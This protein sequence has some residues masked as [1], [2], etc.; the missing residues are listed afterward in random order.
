MLKLMKLELKRFKLKGYM[1]GFAICSI[2]ISAFMIMMIFSPKFDDS[3]VV[4]NYEMLFVMI[5]TFIR[6]TF[7]V[8]AGVLIAN[9]VVSEFKDRSITVLF[10][11]P[12]PRK[13]LL[14]AKLLIVV[15][16]TYFAMLLSYIIVGTI[17]VTVSQFT[18]LIPGSLTFDLIQKNAVVFTYSALAATGMSLISLFFGMR[19]K[20]T[21][22]TI[23]SS[24][25]LVMIVCSNNMGYSLD[26]IIIIPI[27]L[28]LIGVSIAYLSINKI[29]HVD[30]N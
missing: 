11:Y 28:S 24:V 20:S 25:I 26:Q 30:I 22:A 4:E 18:D 1:I 7:M 27:I 19:K 13:K 15:I 29:D 5:S 10:L 23:V 16:L 9:L 8:Y 2:V 17:A 6:A 12:I 3:R 21:V 14:T